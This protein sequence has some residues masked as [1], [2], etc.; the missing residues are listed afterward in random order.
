[1]LLVLEAIPSDL[2]GLISE[3][4]DIPVIGI[5]AGKDTDGQVLV[6]HDMLNYGVEHKAKFVKQ[7]A[8]FSVGVDGLKQ[9][10]QEVKSGAFPSE[11][12]TYKKKIMNEVNN[13]D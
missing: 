8:D 7:F 1:M 4:L 9:Y 11:A 12:Y 6:Y 10:D 5:G 13:N 3:Q 2:A